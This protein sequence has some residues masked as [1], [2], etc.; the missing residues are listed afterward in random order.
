VVA[1]A[2]DTY[3]V[4][5]LT[6][7]AD[8]VTVTNGTGVSG[9]PTVDIASTYVGQTSITTLG[10]VTTG[11]WS[12]TTIA[13]TKGGTGL[14]A[15]TTG[16]ILYASAAD[17][18]SA[19]TIGT[20]GQVLTVSGGVPVWA[21]PAAGHDSVTLAAIGTTP[22]ANAAT[23]TNQVL[24]LEPASASFGGVVT[25]T[26][27]TFAGAK[28]FESTIS[29][30]ETG[31]TPT[32]YT[33]F[34]G[35]DQSGAVTYTLPTSSTN[36]LLRNTG[37]VWS[38]DN[39]TYIS[40]AYSTIQEEGSAVT[41][42]SILNF[43]GSGFTA[44]DDG[45][46]T[47]TNVTLDGGL[48]SLASL[49]TTGIVVASAADTYTVRTLTGTADRVTVTNGTGVSGNP[50][51]DIASTYVG[52]TSITTLGTV[53]TG[54]WSA[55]TIA[56]TKG[57]T[58]LTAYTTGDIL[59]ASAT[60]TLSARAIGTTGQVLTVSGGVP[61]W[62]DPSGTSSIKWNALTAPDGNLTLAHAGYTT[63]FTF[64]S[65]TTA[66]AFDMSSSS[67]THGR[68]LKLSSTSTAG[69]GYGV[70]IMLEIARSG[71]NTNAFHSAY[72]IQSSVSNTGVSASNYSGIFIASGGSFNTGL[73]GSA[74]NSSTNPVSGSHLEGISSFVG[75]QGLGT[76]EDAYSIRASISSPGSGAI[77]NLYGIESNYYASSVTG[78]MYG[79]SIATN[80][81]SAGTNKYGLHIGNV[82]GASTL[83]YA[84]YTNSGS[85]LLN[86]G[87]DANTDFIVRGDTNNNLLFADA[88]TDRVGIGTSSPSTLLQLG[89]AGTT[90]GTL[91][92]AG[93]TSG[94]ITIDT[95]AAAGTWTLTLPDLDGDSGQVLTTDGSGNTSWTTVSTSNLKWNALTAPDGNLT[96]A[97]AGYTTAFTF[98]SVTTATAFDMSSSS[99]TSGS[100]L[101]LSSTSTA[102]VGSGSS[103][104][105]NVSRSGANAN[106]SH[107]AYGILSNVTNT[108][109]TSTN[110]G[111]YFTASGATNNY[112][113]IVSTGSTYASSISAPLMIYLNTTSVANSG[114][115]VK[116]D[117][118]GDA[119]TVYTLAS[120]VNWATGVDNSDS[121]KFKISASMNLGNTNIMTM[122]TTGEVGIGTTTPSTLLQLGNP[123]TKA[124]TLGIAGVTSGLVTI[125]TLA[126]AGT[127]TLTL[128]DLDGDSGQVLTTDGSGN[129]S[130]TT[131][132]SGS[133]LWTDGGTTTYLTATGDNIA[134]GGSTSTSKLMVN[135]TAYSTI[136]L[137]YGGTAVVDIFSNASSNIFIGLD[138]GLAITTGT[139]NIGYGY[140]TLYGTT[141][142]DYNTAIGHQ[143]LVSNVAMQGSTAVGYQA[144]YYANSTATEGLSYNTA[145]GYQALTGS[146]VAANNT[147]VGNTAVGH[148][149]NTTN[150]SGSYNTGLGANSLNSNTD[151]SYNVGLGYNALFTN[152]S[153]QGSTAVGYEA[154][155]YANSSAT[156]QP[157]GNTAIGYQA[158]RGSTTAAN[159]TGTA[160][161]VVGYTAGYSI[162][163]GQYN[164]IL[165]AAAGVTLTTGQQNILI[166]YNVATPSA[167]DSYYLNIGDLILGNMTSGSKRVSIQGSLALLE[168]TGA[169]YYTIF[170]GGDQSANLTYTLPTS[171]TN[172]VLTNT[173][174]TLSWSTTN[175]LLP[176]GT[177]GQM[178][179]NN[180]GTWTAFSGMYWD[181]VNSR[182]GI[183]TTSP[184]AAFQ[185]SSGGAILGSKTLTADGQN[186][187]ILFSNDLGTAAQ[188]GAFFNKLILYGG[189]SQTRDLEFW[190][191]DS[192]Y[193][194]IGT[195]WTGGNILYI[196]SSFLRL[197]VNTA[198][199]V[200]GQLTS[201]LASGT[202]PFV[203]ASST[204]VTNLNAD[205]LDGY[206][207]TGLVSALGLVTGTGTT[208]R[209]V[210]WT[211][212]ST[213]GNGAFL[214]DGT[215][216]AIGTTLSSSATFKVAKSGA[217]TGVSYGIIV[218]N[219]ATNSTTDGIY[220]YGT[221]ITTT[222]AFAGLAGINTTNTSLFIDTPSG[223]DLN[224]ALHVEGGQVRMGNLTANRLV[225]TD[226]FQDLVSTITSANLAL[227]I[228]DETGSGLAVFN[229][230]PT[231]AG[232][233]TT[234][235]TANRLVATNASSQLVSTIT[236]ANLALGISDET[237]SGLAV[238]NTNPSFNGTVYSTGN[239]KVNSDSSTEYFELVKYVP[240]SYYVEIW[241]NGSSR[242]IATT[243]SSIRFKT[244]ITD[245]ELDSS[246]IYN[247]NPVS[248]NWKTDEEGAPKTFGLIAEEIE[249][250]MPELVMYGSDGEI[251]GL[252]YQLI[253]V[254]NLKEIQKH[255]IE[256]NELQTTV[257]SLTSLA[258]DKSM[259]VT[260]SGWYRISQLNGPDDYAKVKINNTTFGSSQ[261]IILSVDTVG[262]AENVNIISNFTT[263]GYDISKARVNSVNGV[264]YLEIYLE[265]V[266]GNSIKVDI[267]GDITNWI[268]I[269]ITKVD[270]TLIV[271]NEFE[272]KGLLFAV[273][274]TL[275]VTENS[276][277]IGG[278]LLTNSD[279]MNNIGDEV[280][281]WNDI[282]TKGAI[283]LGSGVGKEGAIRFNVEL[284]VLEF[285]NDGT[286]WVQL[287][288][289]NSQVV[290]SPEYP[291]AILFADGTENFGSMTS[292][293]EESTGTF[294]NYYE[295][296]S[297]RETLQ[298]YDILV[299][300]T[301]PNDF[302]SWKEDAIYLDFMTEN[303]ASV[304]NNKVD[305]YLMGSS[306]I[307]A[308]VNDGISKLPG[309]WERI[310]I[311]GLDISD[312]NNAGDT[313][314]LRISLSSLQ[315]YFVRV[316]DITLN[317]NRGL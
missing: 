65:V 151:G 6:G 90:A 314:T 302:V 275:D 58:G 29:I 163:S 260:N 53:T 179:Y 316:G 84:I 89:T 242:A 136:E 253:S 244:N 270:D 135:T 219:T 51:V 303:S 24:N 73:L 119:S 13:T 200:S 226:I 259:T 69:S 312:C 172:G 308:Q 133:S 190:Q 164:T 211:G 170:Q 251:M 2:A 209:N 91:S 206:H 68:L 284:Q 55:T 70:S 238:F 271:D 117:G 254:L 193:A 182:L 250:Y 224:L 159:N 110:I 12:A 130:W 186:N 300:V 237:G 295:W 317:Y 210:R 243:T 116:Q 174:G 279:A 75:T 80:T 59:Y 277:K 63:A 56:T 153:L 286:T 181:D 60:N 43:V 214:D 96:L 99:L 241:V 307:D 152:V 166:G 263:G 140:N 107:T 112:G 184:S 95:L 20:V 71:T 57:G 98:D 103:Y 268:G 142:G 225:A 18:L 207:V 255:E 149:A 236:S 234:A 127:W 262:E 1:S 289:L 216:A 247:F 44:A 28:S 195:S 167:T 176:T 85:V 146:G 155:R 217:Q 147:G 126:A 104:I 125:D 32:Y 132:S 76:V 81:G 290:I 273:S 276:V 305:M 108:G 50:T 293:A 245:L 61:V 8:R 162:T 294:R 264:K 246:L 115:L 114:L 281:R 239:V 5:T 265:T 169:T 88:S 231:F 145:I 131:V 120:V 25:T 79:V 54:T 45:A 180:A 232:T 4:R 168:S 171:S 257:E 23:L 22:N 158:L 301:L 298:D 258:T 198:L 118:T 154:M 123:T 128:P 227:G 297:D 100:V 66:T 16:D 72:G 269:D 83:N 141:I 17:T 248:F 252:H 306:G 39:T 212:T 34:Q 282:Y 285:S 194:H 156:G 77:T 177:E 42:R 105:L 221:Y 261:N 31:T 204:L 256:I 165:G 240:A 139:G 291:G 10:T 7:T 109:S 223:A 30:K 86:A 92:L 129:T 143:V 266:N 230:S 14:T 315:S 67:L 267:D 160:N 215:V 189:G 191:E 78:N 249:P 272:F 283:R 222:G 183:G 304:N 228:S 74:Y 235:L 40:Q 311:K 52:Q 11:T 157:S 203:V 138:S 137:Q 48:N 106:A 280:N 233:I 188:S 134:I 299:R 27:Q 122:Y 38:W 220:K 173:S 218:Y 185:V 9:N 313:C 46:N 111:G 35:G 19:R 199:S 310:S 208:G 229:S 47:R 101:G 82:S 3:T 148:Q 62:A 41:Q 144:M 113:L 124:G 49:A 201:T 296:V 278:N 196:D 178:L 287:G 94:L 205:M 161:T 33:T 21:T 15:Y 175:S 102:G 64:D 292:D 97:H 26:T 213:V 150:T 121:D 309:A 37:G 197:D 187:I 93:G 274:E 36:G 87:G 202:A 192:G 288:D